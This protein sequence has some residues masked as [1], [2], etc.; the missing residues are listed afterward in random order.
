MLRA[1]LD[2]GASAFLEESSEAIAG[3]LDATAF[4]S[5]LSLASRKAPRR[6][7]APTAEERASAGRILP[8]WN[9]E[10]WSI[11]EAL[12]VALVLA[13]RDLAEDS[14]VA[15]LEDA[16]RYADEGELVALYRSLAF[17]PRGERFVARAGEGCRTNIR[18]VFEAVATDN[19]FPFRYFGELAFNQMVIKAL[20]VGA[21]A[22]RIYGLDRRVS[23]ELA[24]MALDLCDE[25]RSARRAV[26][27]ELWMCLGS[28]GGERA[29]VALEHE[30]LHGEK[31]GRMAA[32]IALVRAGQGQGLHVHLEHER[33]QEVARTMRAALEGNASQ[34]AFGPIVEQRI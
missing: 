33:D 26:Q 15:A 11:L 30:L 34:E 24:R 25:R 3:G 14:A 20:F 5:R 21:P 6:A 10:R 27:T 19:P 29:R 28:H 2:A 13:R 31:A 22:W 16:F 17:L 32:A 4:A 7:L 23:P 1:R 18:F 8:G 12:R 9:P